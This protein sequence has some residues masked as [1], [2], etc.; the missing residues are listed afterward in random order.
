MVMALTRMT[1]SHCPMTLSPPKPAISTPCTA[2]R[3]HLSPVSAPR[4]IPRRRSAGSIGQQPPNSASQARRRSQWSSPAEMSGQQAALATGV[5]LSVPG[6]LPLHVPPLH[7]DYAQDAREITS[8][9]A[10]V[11]SANV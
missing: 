8:S 9:F 2:Q 1:E 10:G 11:S 4:S 6:D 7:M 3:A 5:I